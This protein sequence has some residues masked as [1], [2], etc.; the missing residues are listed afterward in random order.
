MGIDA[1]TRGVITRSRWAYRHEIGSYRCLMRIHPGR[2]LR[3]SSR[4]AQD[5]PDIIVHAKHHW[6]FVHGSG[7]QILRL[8]WPPMAFELINMPACIQVDAIGV[9]LANRLDLWI[10]QIE[11]IPQLLANTDEVHVIVIGSH[12][13]TTGRCQPTAGSKQHI[14]NGLEII[15]C[16]SVGQAKGSIGMPLPHHMGNTPR[17]PR[18]LHIILSG[19]VQRIRKINRR[20]HGKQRIRDHEHHCAC[21]QIRSHGPQPALVKPINQ[22]R[23]ADEEKL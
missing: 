4:V 23:W 21:N 15:L 12:G 1:C 14:L 22:P 13:Y 8:G 6:Q 3:C 9:A 10:Q 19:S 17:V 18:N 16:M 11:A 7:D 5:T 2:Q 20:L